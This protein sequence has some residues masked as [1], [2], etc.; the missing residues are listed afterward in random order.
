MSL[1]SDDFFD[2]HWLR[3]PFFHAG[4]APDLAGLYGVEDFLCDLALVQAPPFVSARLQ[5]GARV[6]ARSATTAE[7]RT[8]V[9]A[10]GVAAI[11][12]SR[13]WRRASPPRWT[14]MRDLFDA[15]CRQVCM[16]SLDPE[17]TEDADLFL[18]GPNSGFGAHF[19][20]THVFT[21]QL[22]GERAWRVEAECGGEAQIADLRAASG[23]RIREAPIREPTIDIVLRPGD[24]LY[25]P[26]YAVHRVSGVGWSIALSLGLRAIN[27]FDVVKTLLDRAEQAP[28]ASSP[29]RLDMASR[30]RALVARLSRDAETLGVDASPQQR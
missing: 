5:D 22:F 27:E 21:F 12:L 20:A 19:D 28:S 2:R 18:A 8:A 14:W 25:V 23:D 9:A 3:R 10:G 11:K 17:R 7:L 1:T 30:L 6:F 16:V 13:F 24:I 4:G 29:S 15:L 26:A